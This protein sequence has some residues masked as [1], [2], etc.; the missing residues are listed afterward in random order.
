MIKHSGEAS[1]GLAKER[2]GSRAKTLLL[3]KSQI[4][5]GVILMPFVYRYVRKP[6][7]EK[8]SVSFIQALSIT[9]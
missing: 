8:V 5:M 4:K 7:I 1:P 2:P 3:V 6:V 9:I